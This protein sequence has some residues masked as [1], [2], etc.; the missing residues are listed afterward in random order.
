MACEV[1][2]QYGREIELRALDKQSNKRLR[3]K[4]LSRDTV[5][6]KLREGPAWRLG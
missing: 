4:E 1:D 6:N 3:S 2:D 5:L